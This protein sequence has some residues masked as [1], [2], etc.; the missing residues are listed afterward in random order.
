MIAKQL[1]Y[2][3][4]NWYGEVHKLWTYAKSPAGAHRQFMSRL[5]SLLKVT[6]YLVRYYYSKDKDNF[7]ITK[8]EK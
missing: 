7:K 6:G 3:E 2:G 1:Y 8:K 4:Y 5:A